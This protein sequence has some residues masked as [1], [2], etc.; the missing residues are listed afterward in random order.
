MPLLH[1][2]GALLLHTVVWQA[3]FPHHMH[4]YLTVSKRCWPDSVA[5]CVA[6]DVASLIAS[7]IT[8]PLYPIDLTQ[9]L[10]SVVCTGSYAQLIV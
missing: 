8:S 2:I 4:I 7:P 5:S 9:G 10:N 1:V 6:S 3:M